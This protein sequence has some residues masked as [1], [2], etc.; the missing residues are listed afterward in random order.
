MRGALRKGG[1]GKSDP[2]LGG[3][4]RVNHSA[5]VEMPDKTSACRK[6]RFL[7]A[8]FAYFQKFWAFGTRK[9]LHAVVVRTS[10]S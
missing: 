2:G 9:S 3:V 5:P 1:G 6:G 4:Y 10:E 8:P 7:A